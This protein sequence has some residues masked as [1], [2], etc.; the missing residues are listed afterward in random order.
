MDGD[1]DASFPYLVQHHSRSGTPG[2]ENAAAEFSQVDQL[3]GAFQQL[4]ANPYALLAV[5]TSCS[6]AFLCIGIYTCVFSRF[7]SS[8]GIPKPDPALDRRRAEKFPPG[9]PNAWFK[10]CDCDEVKPGEVKQVTALG[11]E[12]AVFR[13]ENGKISVLDAYCPHLS[14]NLTQGQV[15]GE[16]LQCPF[17][18]WKFGTDGQCVSIPYATKI[19]KGATTRSWKCIERWNMVM[20]WYHCDL[21]ESHWEPV[22][23]P[24]LLLEQPYTLRYKFDNVAN[25]HIQDFAENGADW[26]HFSPVHGKMTIPLTNHFLKVRHDTAWRNG[27]Y[28]ADDYHMGWF[29]DDADLMWKWS[30]KDVI[31]NAG[32]K[33]SAT[34]HGPGLVVF[35]FVTYYGTVV[36][37]KTFTPTEPLMQRMEDRIYATPGMW[38]L[39]VKYVVMEANTQ[40]NEDIR[41]WSRKSYSH[42]PL[43]IKEDGNILGIRRWYKQFYSKNSRRG[44]DM[45]W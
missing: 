4:L 5:V 23:L 1:T 14:A 21:E 25:M 44:I 18:A 28:G 12:F 27:S 31:P 3:I 45:T 15:V 22:E 32:A 13:T 11:K 39:L 38:N 41:I 30:E 29:T 43:V 9:Y 20:V 24:E 17:H 37:V 33:A 36:L 35:R 16:S 19:P 6:F 34:F 7:A 8:S 10:L 26:A 2:I 40:F 42:K